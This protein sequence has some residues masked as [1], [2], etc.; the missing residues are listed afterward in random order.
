MKSVFIHADLHRD[1]RVEVMTRTLREAFNVF[2][3]FAYDCEGL[4][5]R[6][7][8]ATPA[9][10]EW[11]RRI[12]PDLAALA[13]TEHLHL[14]EGTPEARHMLELLLGSVDAV[15]AVQTRTDFYYMSGS[16][17]LAELEVAAALNLRSG[18]PR[19]FNFGSENVDSAVGRNF[20]KRSVHVEGDAIAAAR[21]IVA[22]LK[23]R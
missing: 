6:A 13:N 9:E 12:S 4:P 8:L 17:N 2:F 11:L 14:R 5:S 20:T 10:S 1:S 18:G 23:P 19:L 7:C 3:G 22:S 21:T 15:V 16:A